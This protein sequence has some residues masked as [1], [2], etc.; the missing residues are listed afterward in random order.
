METCKLDESGKR[1]AYVA[2]RAAK[3]SDWIDVILRELEALHD[4]LKSQNRSEEWYRMLKVH[5]G[6]IVNAIRDVMKMAPSELFSYNEMIAE[7]RSLHALCTKTE[8]EPTDQNIT[9]LV[10]R[11]IELMRLR[12]SILFFLSDTQ[13]HMLMDSVRNLLETEY[14][15]D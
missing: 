7:I 2:L 8:S 3:I 14:G 11:S 12:D 13:G 10:N 1:T 4:M 5:T 6:R 15:E 9:N